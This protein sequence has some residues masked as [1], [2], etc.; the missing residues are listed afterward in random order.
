MVA[1]GLWALI[2]LPP[3]VCA[4]QEESAPKSSETSDPTAALAGPVI[5]LDPYTVLEEPPK[6]CFDIALE[7][8][9]DLNTGKVTSIYITKV[10]PLSH[11]EELGLV[12]RTRIDRIDGI[13]V[14]N[15]VPSF[16]NG[17]VLNRTFINRKFG[18][19]VTLEVVLPG[20][21]ES[22][23]VTVIEKP[24]IDFRFR[25]RTRSVSLR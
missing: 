11:A 24:N 5:K 17:T 6:L 8:W 4:A 18:A 3:T 12:P 23:T 10:K 2:A 22:K 20:S 21:P 14:E 16:R 13:P 15:L 25:D 1:S 9:G 19:R 7:V